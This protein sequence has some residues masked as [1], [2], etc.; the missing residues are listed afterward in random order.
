MATYKPAGYQD[1]L[2][3]DPASG[4]I[5]YGN[6]EFFADQVGV[7]PSRQTFDFD[8]YRKS[9][10]GT[11][12]VAGG[13]S[14]IDSARMMFASMDETAMRQQF[15]KD[16]QSGVLREAAKPTGMAALAG[17]LYGT[18]AYE[19]AEAPTWAGITGA[20]QAAGYTAPSPYRN[21]QQTDP[22]T[23]SVTSYDIPKDIEFVNRLNTMAANLSSNAAAGQT[24]DPDAAKRSA[25]GNSRL[26]KPNYSRAA[27]I[28]AG[29]Q[30]PLGGA[31]TTL[32]A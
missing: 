20:W 22:N 28:L 15:A 29:E 18:P 10:A 21:V 17:K 13:L 24:S 1:S 23:Y 11:Q 26:G 5:K 6:Y 7:Q 16:V 25:A 8:T 12:P 2:Q 3:F 19:R 31:A 30:S 27:T 9:F 32:G 4:I 14:N